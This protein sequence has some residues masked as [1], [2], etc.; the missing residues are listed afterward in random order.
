M[1][2]DGIGKLKSEM[3]RHHK[4][5]FSFPCAALLLCLAFL[6]L[7]A[8]SKTPAEYRA[9]VKKAADL[10]VKF[11]DLYTDGLREEEYIKTERE[12]T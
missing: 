6:P 1:A 2:I 3:N 7:T 4:N 5:K 11:S 12:I 8:L 9:S 10:I